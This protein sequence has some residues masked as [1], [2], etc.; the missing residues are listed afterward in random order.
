MCEAES[1]ER[2][3][4]KGGRGVGEK[5]V[6]V[7]GVEASREKVRKELEWACVIVV[8]AQQIGIKSKVQE[9]ESWQYCCVFYSWL[10][11]DYTGKLTHI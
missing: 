3:R 5:S 11:E 8:E 1:E 2:E 9:E 7:C 6:Y 4:R 10:V